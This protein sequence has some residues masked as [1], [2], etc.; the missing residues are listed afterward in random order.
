MCRYLLLKQI[1]APNAHIVSTE[2]SVADEITSINHHAQLDHR[3]SHHLHHHHHDDHHLHQMQH[4]HHPP[5]ALHQSLLLGPL[6]YHPHHHRHV[7][8]YCLAC[9]FA[10]SPYTLH[11]Y[12][13]MEG[14]LPR[15]LS[16]KEYF[17]KSLHFK[18]LLLSNSLFP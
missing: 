10:P 1:P 11:A 6:L 16:K 2:Q 9:S 3:S 12:E 13:K 17:S 7:D 8:L 18:P 4:H 15:L 14:F 5:M